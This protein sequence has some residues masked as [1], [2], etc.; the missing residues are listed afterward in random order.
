MK[1]YLKILLITF[2]IL[3]FS[4]S[5]D[6]G[7]NNVDEGG[8]GLVAQATY[9][10]TFESNFTAETHPT[11][12]P[13]NASF[14]PM[15][16]VAHGSSTS[17]FTKGQLAS[18]GMELL[19]EEGDNSVITTEHTPVQDNDNPTI[20]RIGS[21][22]GPTGSTS[23]ELTITPSTTLLSFVTGISPSPDWFL[24]VDSFNFVNPDN[25]SLVDEVELSLTPFDAGTDAGTT[26]T[27]DDEESSQNIS[28]FG[29]APF[30]S[31]NSGFITKLGTLKIER[32][33]Q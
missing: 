31:S 11:D 26:Y 33:D 24:G 30:Q 28:I 10:I 23:V 13:S 20:I 25:I 21:A 29:G 27:S 15:F 14:T 17:V 18:A 22:I 7:G 4:C 8:G 5:S 16:V 6:D 1:N 3:S 32:I 2:S 12:Y 9:R 19:V